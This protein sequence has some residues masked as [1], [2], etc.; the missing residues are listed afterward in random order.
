MSYKRMTD[1]SDGANFAVVPITANFRPPPQS[2][3]ARG[4]VLALCLAYRRNRRV[5]LYLSLQDMI[6]GVGYEVELELALELQILRR[7]YNQ[8]IT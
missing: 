3:L 5:Y 6:E 7:L 2:L 1:D 4:P 8:N